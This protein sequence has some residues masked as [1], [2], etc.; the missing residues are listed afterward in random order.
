MLLFSEN[1]V[2]YGILIGLVFG[3]LTGWLLRGQLAK[4]CVTT[5]KDD[6]VYK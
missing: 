1:S 2:Y 3:I 4:E 6:K 5:T